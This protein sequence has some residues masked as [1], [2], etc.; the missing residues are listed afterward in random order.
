MKL[1]IRPTDRVFV[2]ACDS[3]GLAVAAGRRYKGLRGM[4]WRRIRGVGWVAE[5][6]EHWPYVCLDR[7]QVW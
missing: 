6:R 2:F 3:T 4:R 5:P 7:R 1:E